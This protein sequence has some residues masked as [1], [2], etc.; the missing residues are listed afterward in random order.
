[1][2]CPS[3]PVGILDSRPEVFHL[4]RH[5]AGVNWYRYHLRELRTVTAAETVAL[6]LEGAA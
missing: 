6:G 1:M 5:L 3:A 2:H 4:N